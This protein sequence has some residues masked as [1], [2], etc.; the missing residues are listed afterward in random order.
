[1]Q[2]FIGH[3]YKNGEPT[4]KEYGYF[5]KSRSEAVSH[6]LYTERLSNGS[7]YVGPTG[8]VV[9]SGNRWIVI[10]QP[11]DTDNDAD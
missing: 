10:A 3:E 9:Y 11:K 8:F 7:A 1:M 2:V 4:G 5:A 6:C